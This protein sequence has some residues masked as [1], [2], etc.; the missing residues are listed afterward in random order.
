MV[1]TGR[2]VR[3][4]QHR[5]HFQTESLLSTPVSL[6]HRQLVTLL[7]PFPT[8]QDEGVVSIFT[9]KEKAHSFLQLSSYVPFTV[10]TEQRGMT[11]C[12]PF[13]PFSN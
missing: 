7:Q 6:G 2:E 12:K 8:H 5:H 11:V 13:N 4:L 10:S 1:P 3:H 9:F